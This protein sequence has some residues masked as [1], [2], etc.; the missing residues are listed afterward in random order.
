[1]RLVYKKKL[2]EVVKNRKKAN[3]PI[4]MLTRPYKH[5]TEKAIQM[6]LNDTK[7]CSFSLIIGK[8]P[9]K[10]PQKELFFTPLIS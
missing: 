9:V 4:D 8:K 6:I 2:L 10:K 1:M 5:T 3:N 7:R